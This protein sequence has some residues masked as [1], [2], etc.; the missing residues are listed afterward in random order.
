MEKY[1]KKLKN[2]ERST[3]ILILLPIISVCI[4]YFGVKFYL[5]S[6]NQYND[7]PV[8]EIV[9]EV[10][11]NESQNNITNDEESASNNDNNETMTTSTIGPIE[12]YSIQCGAFSTEENATTFKN[13]LLD[14]GIQSFILKSNNYK[15][16]AYVS[17]N[18]DSLSDSLEKVRE[19]VSDAFIKSVNMISE[20]KNYYIDHRDPLKL[21]NESLK[22]IFAGNANA[23][24]QS[25]LKDKIS[26]F[27]GLSS[28]LAKIHSENKNIA[29]EITKFAD[30]FQDDIEGYSS[31]ALES[32]NELFYDLVINFKDNLE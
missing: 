23:F 6:N 16:F 4:G 26:E 30:Q 21:F 5:L 22:E 27:N 12:F 24:N 11:E 29:N 31:I 1:I 9:N 28:E 18:K 20:N 15:V 8:N 7:E 25:Y 13:D 19:E 2:M 17:L 14:K 32:S 3:L 10:E